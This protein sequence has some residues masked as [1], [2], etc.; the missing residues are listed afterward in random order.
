MPLPP[1]SEAPWWSVAP[2]GGGL[3]DSAR[4][5]SEGLL[6]REANSVYYRYFAHHV[7]LNFPGELMVH[8]AKICTDC[9]KHLGLSPLAGPV[10][11]AGN[12][13][14]QGH[15][16]APQP[17]VRAGDKTLASGMERSRFPVGR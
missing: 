15:G 13:L 5:L 3:R 8:A 17:H 6:H 12:V 10:W 14:E 1:A 4:D 7:F 2:G 9:G 16:K 11:R